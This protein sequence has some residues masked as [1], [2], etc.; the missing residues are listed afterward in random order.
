MMG[1]DRFQPGPYT[2]FCFIAPLGAK[3]ECRDRVRLYFPSLYCIDHFISD[4]KISLVSARG[5][6]LLQ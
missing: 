1:M 4:E 5:D 3:K 2:L 6:A